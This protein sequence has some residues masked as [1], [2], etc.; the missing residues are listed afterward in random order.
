MIKKQ[1]EKEESKIKEI[2]KR[3]TL[4]LKVPLSHNLAEPA[5]FFLFSLAE[6]A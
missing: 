6:E 3:K 5:L 4:L 1:I 2:M